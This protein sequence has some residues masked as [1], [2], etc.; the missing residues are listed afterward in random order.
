[1]ELD[2]RNASRKGNTAP[3]TPQEL[4]DEIAGHLELAPAVDERS[5]S[6]R[7]GTADKTSKYSGTRKTVCCGKATEHNPWDC[8]HACLVCA[9]HLCPKT[10]GGICL[11]DDP[12]RPTAETLKNAHGLLIKKT[13]NT[14]T[15]SSSARRRSGTSTTR[16]AARRPTSL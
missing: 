12:S 13:K 7:V 5:A 4:C 10:H 1:M 11:K 8:P 3:W 16:T 2:L 9:D 6:V 15:S 14:A